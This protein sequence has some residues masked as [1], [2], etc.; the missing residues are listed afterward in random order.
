MAVT[1]GILHRSGAA[2]YAAPT[3]LSA[4][5]LGVGEVRRALLI[6]SPGQSALRARVRVIGDGLEFPGAQNNILWRG[7]VA[8][9]HELHLPLDVRATRT[10]VARARVLLETEEGT[11]LDE[12]T[13]EVFVAP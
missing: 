12:G 5:P 1:P 4:A 3:N 10:G 13:V 6:L 8:Q 9:S 2:S 11:I 7:A